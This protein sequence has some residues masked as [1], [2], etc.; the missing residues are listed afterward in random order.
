MSIFDRTVDNLLG[1]ISTVSEVNRA[2]NE[3]ENSL[4]TFNSLSKGLMRRPPSQMVPKFDVSLPVIVSSSFGADKTE[5]VE[6]SQGNKYFFIFKQSNVEVLNWETGES[7]FSGNVPYLDNLGQNKFIKLIRLSDSVIVLNSDVTVLKDE[8]ANTNEIGFNNFQKTIYVKNG[9]FNRKYEIKIEYLGTEYTLATY[10]TP[11]ETDVNAVDLTHNETIANQLHDQ[12]VAF[13]YVTPAI[14]ID[15]TYFFRKR[16]VISYGSFGDIPF[17]TPEIIFTGTDGQDDNNMVV[18]NKSV[19]SL[20]D[21]PPFTGRGAIVKIEN[22]QTTNIDDYYLKFESDSSEF[23][24]LEGNWVETTDPSIDVGFDLDTMPVKFNLSTVIVTQETIDWGRKLVGDENTNKLPSFIDKKIND[25]GFY[26]NRLFFIYDEFINFTESDSLTNF[27]KASV[28]TELATAPVELTYTDNNYN[29]IDYGIVYNDNLVLFSKERQFMVTTDGNVLKNGTTYIKKLS[30]FKMD[31]SVRALSNNDRLFFADNSN[32]NRPII[33]EMFINREGIIRIFP[34]N[35]SVELEQKGNVDK[36]FAYRNN[37][38]FRFKPE[39]IFSLPLETKLWTYQYITNN[40][41]EKVLQAFQKW[42][43]ESTIGSHQIIDEDEL[44]LIHNNGDRVMINLDDDTNETYVM[45]NLNLTVERDKVYLDSYLA[46][47]AAENS[48]VPLPAGALPVVYDNILDRT[49]INLV[50][51]S[52]FRGH[53]HE[54]TSFDLTTDSTC[55][56]LKENVKFQK[57]QKI[58]IVDVQSNLIVLDGDVTDTDIIIGNVYNT[59]INLSKYILQS[60]AFQG[61]PVVPILDGRTQL[62][63]IG[64]NHFETI[65][66]D[67]EVV[68]DNRDSK[69]KTF[70]NVQANANLEKQLDTG[71]FNVKINSRNEKTKLIIKSKDWSP[72]AV[73]GITYRIDF[74]KTR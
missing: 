46:I 52:N 3:L 64:I 40:E 12:L 71:V 42:D 31:T 39:S 23:L 45:E 55:L 69:I 14:P 36:I 57:N 61:A 56:V 1:G 37:I 49:L 38:F 17:Q 8:V 65:S 5:L 26:R 2:Q 28:I 60:R 19:R 10:E 33:Y 68:R 50:A 13:D 70:D 58:E 22:L 21:L 44:F 47:S 25:V 11:A 15:P 29:P 18:I 9:E 43:S 20:E 51:L 53:L 41:S 30:E 27:F 63:K 32:T 48:P 59:Q 62:L 74:T 66:Y 34:I 35:E 54:L 6:D 67:V 7:L 16:N 73:Q 24:P 4:N 72:L